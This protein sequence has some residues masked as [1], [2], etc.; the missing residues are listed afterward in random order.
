MIPSNS[1]EMFD[2]GAEVQNVFSEKS[3][4]NQ[5]SITLTFKILY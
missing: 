1:N 3:I 2:E 4:E 5:S